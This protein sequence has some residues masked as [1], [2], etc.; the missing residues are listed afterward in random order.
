M[1]LVLAGGCTTTLSFTLGFK[2]ASCVPFMACSFARVSACPRSSQQGTKHHHV[3][4]M[5]VLV[6]CYLVGGEVLGPPIAKAAWQCPPSPKIPRFTWIH[7]PQDSL[8]SMI[9]SSLAQAVAFELCNV[10]PRGSWHAFCGIS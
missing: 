5:L 6:Y 1:V 2:V 3:T 4:I 10:T 8:I 9:P 7:D